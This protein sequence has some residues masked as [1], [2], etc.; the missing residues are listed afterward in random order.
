MS[1]FNRI[2]DFFR[3]EAVTIGL[4]TE[5]QSVLDHPKIAGD[6]A[7][8]QRIKDSLARYEG[9][10]PAIVYRNSNGNTKRRKPGTINMMKKVASKYATVV[11]NEQCEIAVGKKTDTELSSFINGVFEHNDFKKNF[12][13]YLEPMFAI[14]GLACRPYYDAAQNQIEFSWALPD[15]FYPLHSNT[16][17]ISECALTFRTTKTV[18]DKNIYYT[19]I[20]FH[21][22]QNGHYIIANELYRSEQSNIVGILVPLSEVYEDLQPETTLKDL[23]RPLFAYLKPSGFNNINPYSNLGLGVCDNCKDT[24]D[25][26]NRTFDQ[27]DQEITKGKRRILVSEH[28]LNSRMDEQGNIKLFF[29]D[30]EDVFQKIPSGGLDDYTIKDLTSEIRSTQYIDTINHHFKTLEM[31][32]GLSAGTFYFDGRSTKTATEIVAENTQTYQ[33][34]SMQI[35]EVEKFIKELVVSVCELGNALGVYK[36]AIP[37]FSDI[38]VDFRDGAFQSTDEKITYYQKLITMGYPTSKALEEILELP[39]G[40]GQ[41]LLSE[42]LRESGARM[43]GMIPDLPTEAE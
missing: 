12:S 37:K 33:S 32:T 19:L 25:R 16:N 34:R 22:W 17:N 29:D 15:A 14:G 26:I 41:A 20:E 8:Y 13:K 40:Q 21:E 30:T 43:S 3:K 27:Y 36:G 10:Y 7:E 2:R 39:E 9:D 5:L 35:T 28:L 24:L 42:G 4:K 11:F 38:G 31:E 23:S 1:I 6:K 18:G